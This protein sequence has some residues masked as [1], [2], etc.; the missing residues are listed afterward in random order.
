MSSPINA[1]KCQE[2][3]D[4]LG[5][6]FAQ[7]YHRMQ[8]Q[9]RAGEKQYHP[10]DPRAYPHLNPLNARLAAEAAAGIDPRFDEKQA[11]RELKMADRIVGALKDGSADHALIEDLEHGYVA[12]CHE[13]ARWAGLEVVHG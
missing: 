2:L 10:Y 4:R 7:A 8:V 9:Q 13:A 6:T 5:I 11:M 12:R 1:T 3:A